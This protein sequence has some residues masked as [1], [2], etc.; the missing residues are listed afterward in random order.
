MG[1][2]TRSLKELNSNRPSEDVS[3][4]ADAIAHTRDQMGNTLEEIHGILNPGKVIPVSVSLTKV[5]PAT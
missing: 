3:S 4:L 2:S 5:T 1:S